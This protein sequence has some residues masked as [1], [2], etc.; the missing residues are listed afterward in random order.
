M[1]HLSHIAFTATAALV[2]AAVLPSCNRTP[3]E[4]AAAELE[5]MD[6]LPEHY[7]NKM[8]EYTRE[9]NTGMMQL[10]LT[11]GAPLKMQ[12]TPGST[13]LH[14]AALHNQDEAATL[15]VQYGLSIETPDAEGNSPLRIAQTNGYT[16]CAQALAAATLSKEGV[17]PEDYR[18]RFPELCLAEDFRRAELI[19]IAG[20]GIDSA[21]VGGYTA[22]HCAAE[23][24]HPAAMQFLI[25]RGASHL[26]QE[27]QGRLPID[28]ARTTGNKHCIRQ[29]AIRTLQREGVHQEAYAATLH[30]A[31]CMGNT[32]RIILLHEAGED[33]H[34]KNN[35]G[36]NL[37]HLAT[38]YSR[39]ESITCLHG[40]G[41]SA[42][43]LNSEHMSPLLLTVHLNKPENIE[44]LH[45]VGADTAATLPNGM[46]AMQLAVQRGAY[47]CLSPLAGIGI[48]SNVADAHGNNLLHYTAAHGQLLCMQ[49]LLGLGTDLH[50]RNKQGWS[51]LHYATSKKQAECARMLIEAG[52]VDDATTAILAGDEAA[53]RQYLSNG[54]DLTLTDALGSTPL[55]WAARLG[56]TE[57]CKLLV[58]HGADPAATDKEDRIPGDRACAAG[59]PDCAKALAMHA[60]NKRKVEPKAYSGALHTAVREGDSATLR[61]LLQAGA[62]A[63]TT[64]REGWPMLHLATRCGHAACVRYLLKHGANPATTTANTYSALHL[65]VSTRKTDC[66]RELLL[67]GANLNQRLS[68]DCAP[69]HLA[70]RMG[71]H[72]CLLLLLEKGADIHARNERG[73]TPLLEVARWGWGSAESLKA[74]LQAGAKV[75]DTNYIGENAL[76]A[77]AAAGNKECLILLLEAGADP[78]ATT[79]AG[80]TPLMVAEQYYQEPCARILR[81]AVASKNSVADNGTPQ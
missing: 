75:S 19:L 23:A 9:G 25:T 40:L 41:V 57:M 34:T 26:V 20:Y 48:D 53:L 54:A 77:A 27:A 8:V 14:L 30:T 29:L 55:H 58:D 38:R 35:K 31:V 11:A 72:P 60:L 80:R 56:H 6:I 59:M 22:L 32:E 12:P 5:D 69:L 61:L 78:T 70:A 37:I 49:T 28:L 66:T 73:D 39:A 65:A 2:C 44:T 43:E 4:E 46:N 74:L 10:L 36:E 18:Q 33:V 3:Q 24:G 1:K 47:Q 13:L 45:Q 17:Q 51:A 68:N 76:H 42:N 81:K 16:D 67:G 63:D 50:L 15:L 71:N 64:N 52:A 62:K 79:R 21:G 7:E